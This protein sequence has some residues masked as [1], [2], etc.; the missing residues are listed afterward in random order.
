MMLCFSVLIVDGSIPLRGE[1]AGA[2]DSFKRTSSQDRSER[3]REIL[4][5]TGAAR[6]EKFS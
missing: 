1:L 4:G 2:V 6:G 5:F 3:I